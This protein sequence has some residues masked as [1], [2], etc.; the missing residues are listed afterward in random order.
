MVASGFNFANSPG[1]DVYYLVN[2]IDSTTALPAITLTDINGEVPQNGAGTLITEMPVTFD[3]DSIT[4][5]EEI[6]LKDGVDNG[7]GTATYA[8]ERR[9]LKKDY[10][11]NPPEAGDVDSGLYKSHEPN[12]VCYFGW[13]AALRLTKSAY[14]TAVLATATQII[15]LLVFDVS[16]NI[17]TG[18]GKAYWSVPLKYNGYLITDIKGY[19]LDPTNKGVTGAT[20]IQL[21]NQTQSADVLSTRVTISAGDVSAA[22]GVI[23]TSEDD[24]T[25][26]DLLAIDVDTTCTTPAK[27]LLIEIVIESP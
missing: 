9:G 5:N 27:G 6:W 26:G 3:A 22:D 25:T 12:A 11:N 10:T 21:R 13:D 24:L 4:Q 15:E 20:T 16:E 2:S 7:N 17:T 23:N 1:R 18:N 19:H 14:D 8:T